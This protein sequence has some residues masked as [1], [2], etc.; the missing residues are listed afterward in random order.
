MKGKLLGVA[1]DR[2]YLRVGGTESIAAD[3]RI[4]AATNRDLER[5]VAD[6]R[7]REDLYFR[8]KVVTLELPPLRERGPRDIERLARHF[9]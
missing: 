8:V 2:A 7:F 5:M 9:L 6:G 3:V 4:V 1:Q